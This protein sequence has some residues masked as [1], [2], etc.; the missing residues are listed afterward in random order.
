M[1]ICSAEGGEHR[2]Q[3]GE[4]L[5]ESSQIVKNRE[6]KDNG[7]KLIFDDPILCAQFL[8]GYVNIELLKNVEP[9]DIEDISERF[10]PMWQEGRD[11]DSVKKIHLKEQS[12]YL[13]AVVEHQSKVHYDMA[14]K[15]L[16]YIVMILTDYE[17]EQEKIHPGITKTKAFQYPP[18]LPIVYYE[19]TETWTAV[20]NF[21]DRVYLSDALEKYIPDFEYLVV[22]LTS[23]SNRELIEKN[24]ELSL[25][26]LIN[27]LRNSMEFRNLREIPKEYFD[28][29]S[30]NTPDYLLTIIGKIIATLLYRMNVP[31]SEVEKFTDQITRREFDMLFD[32]FEAYDVQE[33]RRI[34]RE[35]G[36]IEGEERK[37]VQLTCKKLQKNI[38]IPEIAD[39]L[40]EDE[41]TIQKI[42]DAASKHA[43]EYDI[44][45]IIKDLIQ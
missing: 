39:M 40:E 6:L 14:F 31:R 44:D 21:K 11:S 25:I 28:N 29:L 18:I 2:T 20:R 37:L 41:E 1:V 16:R 19:G 3:K 12:L 13:I 38:S 35:Q 34:S 36:R 10:L 24:D 7:A 33:T 27:K 42:C 17:T 23:Y 45:K 32:S 22:P 4:N 30:E 43:P 9:E 5:S 15:L 8:R 26:F